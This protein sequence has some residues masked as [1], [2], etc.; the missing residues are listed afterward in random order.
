MAGFKATTS[1]VQMDDGVNLRVK[2]I[3]EDSKSTKPLL[4]ALHGAPGLSTSVEPEATFT[5]LSDIFRV[6][7]F[8]ARGSGGSDMTGPYTHDRWIKDIEILRKWACAEKFVL[9][10]WSYGGFISLDYAVLHGDKLLG[11]MLRDTWA[12]GILGQMTVLGNILTDDR[13]HVDV[14]RQVRVWSGNLRDDKDFEEAIP[15]ILPIYAP[16]E[17]PAR[18]VPVKDND[19]PKGF[20]GMDERAAY[21]SATQNAAFSINVPCFD[22][23][24][25]L[26]DI[27]TPTLVLVGRHDRITPVE[28]SQE[29]ANGI[30]GSRLE[31]FEHSGHNPA[32][33]ETEKFRKVTLDFLRTE[34]I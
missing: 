30:P 9:A 26:K 19:E 6:L 31:I 22:V 8:D 4:I 3:G 32:S 28:C 2:V 20:E 5:F 29:I 24:Q 34:V 27:K 12:N 23:R 11:L 7:V 21:N 13:L 17:D 10:G 18:K 33:D 16:P 1:T 14:A 15:E 25:Q